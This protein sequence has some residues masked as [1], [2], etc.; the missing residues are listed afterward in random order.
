ML[1]PGNATVLGGC[2]P[3]LVRLQ[4]KAMEMAAKLAGV[5]IDPTVR[6]LIWNPHTGLE[7]GKSSVVFDNAWLLRS[8][9]F[10]GEM[11]TT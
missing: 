5:G 3:G 10:I 7:E 1:D 6:A 8:L 4:R 2:I 11:H 9:F